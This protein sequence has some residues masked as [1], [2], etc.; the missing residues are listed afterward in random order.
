MFPTKVLL[1]TNGSAES[2]LA[3]EAAVELASGTGSELHVVHVVSMVPEL[4]Y[5][6]AS[7]RERSEVL[8]ERRRL[9]GLGLLDARVRRIEGELGGSVTTSYYR[10]GKPEKETIL[11]GEKLGAG[12]IVIGGNRRPWYERMF[13]GSGYSE[14]VSRQAGRPVLIAG[15][16]KPRHEE[17]VRK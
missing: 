6:R 11:L 1:A 12:L 13:A 17:A 5:P 16:S 4:P 3:E 10:E 9:R 2:S 15:A 14:R 7:S 8:L